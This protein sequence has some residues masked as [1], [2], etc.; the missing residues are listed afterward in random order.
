MLLFF[1]AKEQ[2][3]SCQSRS[4]GDQMWA[5]IKADEYDANRNVT[6]GKCSHENEIL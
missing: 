2:I 4:H 1:N 5:L 3:L 6:H